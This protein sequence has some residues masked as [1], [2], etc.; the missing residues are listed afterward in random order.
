MVSLPLVKVAEEAAVCSGPLRRVAFRA[1]SESEPEIWRRM[2]TCWPRTV[3]EPSHVPSIAGEEARATVAEASRTS[4]ANGF[5][6][7]TF[8]GVRFF[9]S[10]N[11]ESRA[12][13]RV[14]GRLKRATR[15]CA[16]QRRAAATT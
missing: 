10:C 16:G 11:S 15:L 5:P 9:L 4:A 12:K 3:A 13:R 6:A 2:G 8:I 7:K 14:G 1:E